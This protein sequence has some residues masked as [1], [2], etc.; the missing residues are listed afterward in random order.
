MAAQEAH[1]ES[2]KTEASNAFS[3]HDDREGLRLLVDLK[4]A[5]KQDNSLKLQD[6]VCRNFISNRKSEG[7][8]VSE[9]FEDDGYSAKDTRRPELQRM[10]KAIDAGE[11][12]AVVVYKIDR[13][14]RSVADFY[15]LSRSW[16]ER[17]VSFISASQ[18]FDS[19]SVGGRLMLNI[20]LTFA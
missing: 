12:D 14:T 13:L 7:Y 17:D 1:F 16:F 11:I 2:L 18:S 5:Y 4:R 9:V 15:D 6:Q 20:L 10:F 8:V 3:R 19:L